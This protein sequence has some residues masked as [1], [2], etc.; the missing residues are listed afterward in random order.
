LADRPP[1]SLPVWRSIAALGVTQII[2]WG[3]TYYLLTILAGPISRDLGMTPGMTAAGMSV[4]MVLNALS[5]PYAGRLMDVHGAGPVMAA[6]SLVAAAGLVGL[7]FAQ[8]PASFFAAWVVIGVA[9][10]MTLYSAAF[11]ALTQAEPTQAR[12]AITMLTLPGGLASTVFWPLTTWLLN[13]QDWR[14]ICLIYA[15]LNVLICLPLHRFAIPPGGTRN[16]MPDEPAKLIEGLPEGLRRKAFLL[17]AVMLALNSIITVGTLNQFTTFLGALHHLP[18]VIVAA[19]MLFGISQV[20]ARLVEMAF[21]GAYDPLKGTLAITLGYAAAFALLGAFSPL[22]FAAIGFAIVYGASNGL[23]T[24]NRGALVLQLFGSAGYGYMSGK[25]TVAQN[26]VGAAAPIIL[27]TVI[28]H[29]GGTGGI[30]FSLAVALACV[31]AMAA[32]FRH[33]AGA[34]RSQEGG[35]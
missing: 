1:L 4:L 6:G 21:G 17:F 20:S 25:V 12:R 3:S 15:A 18:E 5:G 35:T 33:A 9:C 29:G 19:S 8:G 34:E 2:G 16:A 22:P 14:S 13:V 27:A 7:S 11:T 32:L 30:L 10:S 23:F 31:V 28:G 26:I 24:I